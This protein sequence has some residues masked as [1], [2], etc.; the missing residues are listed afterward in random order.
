MLGGISGSHECGVI[1]LSGRGGVCSETFIDDFELIRLERV[2]DKD[3]MV[4]LDNTDV[5]LFSGL[6]TVYFC[7]IS[8]KIDEFDFE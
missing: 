2:K 7:E 8:C 1:V 4:V 6:Y 3:C 5:A